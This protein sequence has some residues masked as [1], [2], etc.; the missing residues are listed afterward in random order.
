M[1]KL[2]T[3]TTVTRKV[4]IKKRP[5]Q[6]PSF[7]DFA[8]VSSGT[9]GVKLSFGFILSTTE[10]SMDVEEYAHIG[11]TAEHA[12]AFYK[13]LGKHLEAYGKQVGPIRLVPAEDDSEEE[14]AKV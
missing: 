4:A 6:P 14:P 3:K 9:F 2:K 11:M 5:D 1:S 10:D 8:N 7:C 12:L 13:L